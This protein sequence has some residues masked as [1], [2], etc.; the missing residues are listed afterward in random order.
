MHYKFIESPKELSK[1]DYTDIQ[2]LL[3]LLSN[4]EKV[5]DRSSVKKILHGSHILIC[6]DPEKEQ[7]IIG[8][9]CLVEYTTLIESYSR[10]ED[11]IVDSAYRNR[12]IGE[13]LVRRLIQKSKELE[14]KMVWLTCGSH[15][16]AANKLYKK[17]GFHLYDTNVYQYLIQEY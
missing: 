13:E 1:L 3:F 16:E 2:T 4:S 5:M 11:V 9:A 6:R 15:R 10:V 14:I 7:R 12:G 17:T 8:M